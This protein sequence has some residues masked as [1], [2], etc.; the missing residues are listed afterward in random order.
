MRA[1]DFFIV[2]AA[3]SGTT[4]MFRYL[5][6]HPEVFMPA[7]KWINYFNVDLP[8]PANCH[9]WGD[10]LAHFTGAGDAKRVGEASESSLYSRC[11]AAGIRKVC[12]DADIIIMLRNPVDMLHALHSQL[13]YS[14]VEDIEDFAEA[15][16]AEPG[17][18]RGERLPPPAHHPRQWLYYRDAARFAEQV[19]RY[20]D[21][22]GRDR[23]HII[24][25]DDFKADTA[26]VYAGAL[27]FLGVDPG[28]RPAFD[29]HNANAAVRNRGLD[30]FMRRPPESVRRLVRAVLPATGLRRRIVGRLRVLNTTH[31]PRPVL[32]AALRERLQREFAPEV[33]RL[34]ALIGRDL[35]HWCGRAT[36][37]LQAA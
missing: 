32:D 37:P 4:S 1:P 19:Q 13:L 20:L 29:V 23:V 34:G 22:F 17:R 27:R 30:R 12:P 6:E 15:L 16:G 26:G 14:G 9:S 2:G 10:Y 5:G 31:T 35:S 8:S 25:F 36:E 33:A 18:K 7:T 11:A 28:F 3:K 24:L 21:V